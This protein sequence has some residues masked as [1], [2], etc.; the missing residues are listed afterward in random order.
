MK[1]RQRAAH[2]LAGLA[3]GLGLTRR[4]LRRRAAE[5]SLWTRWLRFDVFLRR[6][7][8]FHLGVTPW[9]DVSLLGP[10]WRLI[11]TARTTRYVTLLVE[12]KGHTKVIGR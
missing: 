9:L 3:R 7:F 5:W 10:R 8:A 4:A 11:D 12:V 1:R 6:D 2:A